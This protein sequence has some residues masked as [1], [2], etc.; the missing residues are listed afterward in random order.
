M[1]YKHSPTRWLSLLGSARRFKF[2]FHITKSYFLE[3]LKEKNVKKEI[4]SKRYIRIVNVF[5]IPTIELQLLVLI[6]SALIFQ[7]ALLF[8]QRHEVLIHKLHGCLTNLISTIA[9][10]ICKDDSIEFQNLFNANNIKNNEDL[11]LSLT[12]AQK[13]CDLC[14]TEDQT[15]EFVKGYANHYK[16]AGAYLVSH[17]AKYLPVIKKFESL[18]PT[19]FKSTSAKDNIKELFH[20]FPV[21]NC[22]TEVLIEEFSQ[23]QRENIDFSNREI[24]PIDKFW[25]TLLNEEDY[26][27]KY[28]NIRYLF[29]NLLCITHGQ[30]DIER[31]F[32]I[33]GQYL[34]KKNTRISLKTYNAVLN[35]FDVLFHHK[36]KPQQVE[37]TNELILKAQLARRS[38]EKRTKS[39]KEVSSNFKQKK[40]FFFLSY[41]TNLF[42]FCLQNDVA[43]ELTEE[44]SEIFEDVLTEIDIV[45]TVKEDIEKELNEL[46]VTGKASVSQIKAIQRTNSGQILG[47][48]PSYSRYTELQEQIYYLNDKLLCLEQTKASFIEDLKQNNN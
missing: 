30:S 16:K 41:I 23:L 33:T 25:S 26:R 29:L 35:I 36:N 22:S 11:E 20:L 40:Y 45:E 19:K 43:I 39:T 14:L 47:G 42:F 21:K 38:I 7:P 1:F 4:N 28:K 48:G 18:D 3:H 9:Q 15:N 12:I 46:N 2:L 44:L 10:K 31:H 13:I 37:I 8:L 17:V 32:S 34:T 24:T 6:E 5:N 27:E